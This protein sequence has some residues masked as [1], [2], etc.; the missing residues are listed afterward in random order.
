MLSRHF[1]EIDEVCIMLIQ[2]LRKGLVDESIFWG[3]ELLLSDESDL[4][5]KTA[6]QS[7]I[8]WL[9]ANNIHW[10]DAWI[11][12]EHGGPKLILLAEFC[13]LRT[14]MSKVNKRACLYPFLMCAR[15]SGMV[16]LNEEQITAALNTSNPFLLYYNLG[17]DYL[18]SPT[19]AVEYLSGIVE[20]VVEPLL[21]SVRRLKVVKLKG[22]LLAC[23]V[24]VACLKIY[25]CDLEIS[26]PDYVYNLTMK[27]DSL[28]GR[29]KGRLFAVSDKDAIHGK[30]RVSQYMALGT[31]VQEL[32]KN[33]CAFWKAYGDCDNDEIIDALFPDDIPDEWSKE[34][35]MLSHP[36]KTS[37]YKVFYKHEY[38]FKQLWGFRP[39]IKQ[40]WNDEITV[41]MK[42]TLCPSI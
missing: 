9:G 6:I 25:P 40:A 42:A 31:S 23:A 34:D 3:R 33:G 20:S 8:L 19:F 35:K 4:L 29:R 13:L 24:Q 38:R 39:F 22:L 17:K 10:L 36:I 37:A 41:L 27:W 15:G 11:K 2:S 30:K 18:L 26:M 14:K 1:Y 7:W 16:E 12:C 5:E 21:E 28:I 32:F